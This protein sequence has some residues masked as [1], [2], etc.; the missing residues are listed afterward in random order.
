MIAT[1][2]AAGPTNWTVCP[3]RP[4]DE[5]RWRALYAGYAAFYKIE[6]T[7]SMASQI[8]GWLL[9]PTPITWHDLRHAFGTFLAQS[10][11]PGSTRG[12]W[13]G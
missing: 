10:G 6:Q 5:G 4:E 11:I 2:S 12:K 3:L 13:C 9:D 7:E 8:W 1:P